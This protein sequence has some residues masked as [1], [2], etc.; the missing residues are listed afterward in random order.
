MR[1]TLHPIP[2]IAVTSLACILASS[3]TSEAVQQGSPAPPAAVSGSSAGTDAEGARAPLVLTAL[4]RPK[5]RLEVVPYDQEGRLIPEAHAA[6]SHFLRCQRTGRIKQVHPGVVAL[7]YQLSRDYPGRAIV[8][9]SGFRWRAPGS[10]GQGSP[11]WRARAVD[12]RVA[13]VSP[14]KL[15]ARLWRTYDG[16]AVGYYPARG[17]IHVDVRD[18]PVR[19]VQRGGINHYTAHARAE[20]RSLRSIPTEFPLG[21]PA[22]TRVAIAGRAP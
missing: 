16:I 18:L 17:F 10:A 15:S 21:P 8:V 14:R 5:D 13:G 2:T 9:V 12:L 7:L 1:S 20:L 11:H 6:I 19:W 4:N 22:A 3:T